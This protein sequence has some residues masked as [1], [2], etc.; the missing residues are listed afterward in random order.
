MEQLL[1]RELKTWQKAF[2]AQHGRDP[3][4]RDILAD[5]AIAGTYDTWQ[6]VGGDVNAKPKY[7][8]RDDS[9]ASRGASSSKQRLDGQHEMVKTPSKRRVKEVG[10][11]TPSKN[12]FRTPTKIKF[13]PSTTAVTPGGKSRNP[14]ASPSKASTEA[15]SPAR[16]MIEVEL[17]PTKR[18]PLL[19]TRRNHFTPSKS[20]SQHLQ[21]YITSSP[22]KL[23]TTLAARRTP[24][25]SPSRRAASDAALNAALVAYTPRTK[26]RKRLRAK[27]CRLHRTACCSGRRGGEDGAEAGG[28]GTEG[29]GC[30]WICQ[31]QRGQEE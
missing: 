23:R 22:S 1:R 3:T 24:T 14:F 13:S 9:Q 4:K 15:V 11:G 12:P 31:C 7:R 20:P 25:K 19:E 10:A 6:A 30:V 2:K 26:A 5:P 16:S 8:P 27:M 29:V 21:Q 18:S 17:T 28:G